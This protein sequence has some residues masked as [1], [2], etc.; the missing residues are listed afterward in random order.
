MKFIE[1]EE[2]MNIYSP[3]GSKIIFTGENGQDW[4]Q[5]NARKFL[6]VGEEYTLQCAE[7]FSNSTD[8]VLKEFPKLV[9]NSVLFKNK[10]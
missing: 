8:V 5:E 6:V 2:T 1:P 7:I 9:F 3:P 10:E 4:E